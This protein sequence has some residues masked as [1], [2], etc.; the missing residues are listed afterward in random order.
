MTE[1]YPGQFFH[2]PS[3]HEE[4][5]QTDLHANVSRVEHVSHI[6]S[7]HCRVGN[8]DAI[9]SWRCDLWWGQILI[10]QMKGQNGASFAQKCIGQLP[11]V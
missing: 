6:A 7:Q 8:L 1:T 11:T 4:H 10:S 5:A 3:G 9:V 2:R